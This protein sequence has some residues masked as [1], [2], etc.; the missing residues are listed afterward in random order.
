VGL[1]AEATH[2]LVH[3]LGAAH[4]V[5]VGRHLT[6]PVP[7]LNQPGAFAKRR[8]VAVAGGGVA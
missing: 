1:L 2:R 6:G 7:E 3:A 5:V 4:A 8:L